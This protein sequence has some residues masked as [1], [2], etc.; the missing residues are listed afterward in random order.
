VVDAGKQMLLAALLRYFHHGDTGA[1]ARVCSLSGATDQAADVFSQADLFL[2]LQVAGLIEVSINDGLRTWFAA[3]LEDPFLNGQMP[4]VVGT[5]SAWFRNHAGE[6]RTV[7]RRNSGEPL[8]LGTDTSKQR[9]PHHACNLGP[10]FLQRLPSVRDV[11]AQLVRPEPLPID[12]ADCAV[13]MFDTATARW[14][15]HDDIQTPQNVLIRIRGRFSGWSYWVAGPRS[16]CSFKLLDT[17]WAFLIARNILGW[18]LGDFLKV[19]RGSICLRRA[20]R[21]PCL[22]SR[23]LFANAKSLSTGPM[24]EFAD[25]DDQAA[26]SLLVYLK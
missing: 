3:S 23:F 14:R 22:I 25:I 19:E 9:R 15:L 13:E 7:I 1:F 20:Y 16:R 6:T 4:K 24:L 12:L 11:E 26:E 18:N 2:A 8:L 17:D 10:G 21:L 5:T